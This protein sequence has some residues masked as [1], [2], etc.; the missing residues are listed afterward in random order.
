[1]FERS[2]YERII[3]TDAESAVSAPRYP[4]GGTDPLV[5]NDVDKGAN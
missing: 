4:T 2:W 3:K 1:M 5:K